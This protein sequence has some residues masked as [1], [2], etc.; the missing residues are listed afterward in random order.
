MLHSR[1]QRKSVSLFLWFECFL[2][3]W[4]GIS[5]KKKETKEN[6]PGSLQ[7][8]IWCLVHVLSAQWTV[9][10]CEKPFMYR[11]ANKSTTNKVFISKMATLGTASKQRKCFQNFVKD[12][13]HGQ[14]FLKIIGN[15]K[16]R[17]LC[18]L[19]VYFTLLVNCTGVL[20]FTGET[21]IFVC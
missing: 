10:G 6:K 14:T 8:Q 7:L 2:T 13:L 3:A 20:Y 1:A 18:T 4:T 16:T 5:G 21:E 11:S 19:L 15:W 12:L 9:K 17:R